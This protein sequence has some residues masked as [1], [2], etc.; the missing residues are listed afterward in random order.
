MNQIDIKYVESKL[1]TTPEWKATHILRPDLIVLSSSLQEFG[2]IQPIHIRKQTGEIIDGS[3][4]WLLATNVKTI[5]NKVGD[6]IPVIEHD[7]DSLEAMMM[8]L[9]LNRGKGSIVAKPMSKII[10]KLNMSKKYSSKEFDSLLCMKTDELDLML[11]GGIIK[12]RKIHEHS[13]SRA[14]V[15]VEAPSGTVDVGPSIERPPNADR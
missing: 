3:E 12:S 10:R 5:M 13:Y 7:V 1:L 6:K 11:D 2:F 9:R 14:W 8:H 4:R 15:P